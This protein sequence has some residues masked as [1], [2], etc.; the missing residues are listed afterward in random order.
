MTD[1][2]D[3]VQLGILDTQWIPVVTGN[4][5]FSKFPL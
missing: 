3:I 4:S 2:K 5:H 1:L